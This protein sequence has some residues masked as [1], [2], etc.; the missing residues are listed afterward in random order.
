MDYIWRH[1]AT[2][3]SGTVELGRDLALW[4][5]VGDLVALRG[6]VGVG[7]SVLARAIIRALATSANGATVEVPSPTYTLVE[8]YRDLRL[9]VAHFDLYRIEDPDEVAELG[10]EDA[11]DEAAVLVEWPEKLGNHLPADYLEITLAEQQNDDGAR[12]ITLCG[13]G[14]WAARLKR[15]QA[16]AEFVARSG[17]AGTARHWLKGDA[18][19]RAYQRLVGAQGSAILMDAPAVEPAA[20]AGG[21]RSYATIAGLA[22]DVTAFLAVNE[23]LRRLGLSAPRILSADAE[24]GFM[25]LEDFGVQSFEKI[26]GDGEDLKTPY[27]AALAVLARLQETAP[28]GELPYGGGTHKL[29]TYDLSALLAEVELLV[30]WFWPMHLGTP[31]PPSQITAYKNIWSRALLRLEAPSVLVLRDFHSPNLYWLPRRHGAGRIGI[32]DHQDAAIGHPAFDLMSLAQD[33]RHDLP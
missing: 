24:P 25:L 11:M 23:H 30:Q 15:A 31:C 29:P 14:V 10:F 5:S 1:A 22:T 18:S 12:D 7:K 21:G 9:P 17:W 2:A 33:A 4:L 20:P 26:L 27:R 13:H 16:S 6:P 3:E 19:T 8:T 28:P 32:I